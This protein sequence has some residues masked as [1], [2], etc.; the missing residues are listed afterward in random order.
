MRIFCFNFKSI[1]FFLAK[2][3]NNF[4]NLLHITNII[5]VILKE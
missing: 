2:I 1:D 4:F 3:D 5:L